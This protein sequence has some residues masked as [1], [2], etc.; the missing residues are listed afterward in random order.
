MQQR[1]AEWFQARV[2]F[3]TGSHASDIMD[4]LKTGKEGAGRR[5]YRAQIIA[6]ILTG[7]AVTDG[8]VSPEMIW[9]ND[10]EPAARAA[11]EIEEGAMVQEIGFVAHPTIP[12]MGGS[13]D[14]LVGADGILETKCPK[15]AT[16]LKWILEGIVPPEHEP[17]MSFYLAVTG[18]KWA[19]FVSY[20]P[21]LPKALR[22][23]TIR[24]E[25]NEGRIA[26]IEEAVQNF[27]L[28]VERTIARLQEIC[29]PFDLPAARRPEA[30]AAE[31]EQAAEA[32]LTDAD[33][34]GLK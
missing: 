33:F 17:Q 4:F 10:N 12:R 7:V 19:D 32:W 15:T 9:G 21:R 3:A 11:Y 34:E 24:L 29:G 1:S 6:E 31:E 16:H 30:E 22:M 23:M 26:E 14:G 13:P 2:G 25:R 28:E 18:R 27:N 8:Y 5:N 20:D